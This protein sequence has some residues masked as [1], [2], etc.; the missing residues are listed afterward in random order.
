M[1]VALAFPLLKLSKYAMWVFFVTLNLAMW[2]NGMAYMVAALSGDHWLGSLNSSRDATTRNWTIWSNI[3]I[4][5]APILSG[6]A[7]LICFPIM[8]LGLWRHGIA[9]A[10]KPEDAKIDDKKEE[11]EG[12]HK[13]TVSVEEEKEKKKD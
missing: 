2:T 9:D 13:K 1:V 3:S 6:A 4:L 11:K 8:I 12:K 10:E 5:L 7:Y